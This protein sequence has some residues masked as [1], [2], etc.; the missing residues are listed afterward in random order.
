MG[1]GYDQPTQVGQG[2]FYKTIG[3]SYPFDGKRTIYALGGQHA[4]LW[5]VWAVVGLGYAVEGLLKHDRLQNRY[6]TDGRSLSR[7]GQML[8]FVRS[9]GKS[10]T[11]QEGEERPLLG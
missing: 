6:L 11:R 3:V 4:T 5:V 9:I 7:L 10:R 2:S 1:G 8:A